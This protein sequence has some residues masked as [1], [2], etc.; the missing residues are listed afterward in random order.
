[1]LTTICHSYM[2]KK[3]R[4]LTSLANILFLTERQIIDITINILQREKKKN[5]DIFSI[6]FICEYCMNGTYF[7]LFLL[8]TFDQWSTS[9]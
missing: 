9:N 4:K 2:R 8:L 5:L 7:I 6:T 1:M 3:H